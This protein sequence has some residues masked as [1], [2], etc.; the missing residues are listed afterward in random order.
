[1][2]ESY[3]ELSLSRF[4]LNKQKFKCRYYGH[5]WG[6]GGKKFP[7]NWAPREEAYNELMK[8]MGQKVQRQL[9]VGREGGVVGSQVEPV[10]VEDDRVENQRQGDVEGEDKDK[11]D[12]GDMNKNETG[13]QVEGGGKERI[14]CR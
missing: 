3:L 14:T 4:I 8:I 12:K 1:M 13:K 9:L 11:T 10:C 5:G 7:K 2:H 6:G